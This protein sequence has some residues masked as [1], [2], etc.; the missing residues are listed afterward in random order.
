[1]NSAV[2]SSVEGANTAEAPA[3]PEANYLMAQILLRQC[4]ENPHPHLPFCEQPPYAWH[5]ALS[6]RGPN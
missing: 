5:R 3:D 2:D 6:S 1:M 4:P